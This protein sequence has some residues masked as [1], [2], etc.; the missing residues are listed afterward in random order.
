MLMTLGCSDDDKI[1]P[2]ELSITVV[3]P[4]GADR[5]SDDDDVKAT[6]GMIKLIT[7]SN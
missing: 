2:Q 7:R 6:L 1:L 5:T 4:E 3:V